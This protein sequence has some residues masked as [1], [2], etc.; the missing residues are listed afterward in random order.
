MIS[1]SACTL[2][3]FALAPVQ[4][5][6]PIRATIPVMFGAI[7]PAPLPVARRNSPLGLMINQP[8]SHSPYRIGL[9]SG[10]QLPLFVRCQSDG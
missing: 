9:L 4:E 5:T 10:E 2:F 7:R 3:F 1:Y 8:L 6:I